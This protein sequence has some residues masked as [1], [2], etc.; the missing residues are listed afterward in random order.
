M[1]APSQEEAFKHLEDFLARLGEIV[2][3]RGTAA[4]IEELFSTV[5]DTCGLIETILELAVQ[6]R[7]KQEA[8]V[9]TALDLSGRGTRCIKM[10]LNE[11][12]VLV[13]ESKRRENPVGLRSR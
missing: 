8:Y 11:W 1:L 2:I 5:T 10:F 9:R 7:R 12:K 6:D 3:D 4:R 13:E